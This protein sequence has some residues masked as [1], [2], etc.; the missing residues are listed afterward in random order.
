MLDL[1]TQLKYFTHLYFYVTIDFHVFPYFLP[2]TLILLPLWGKLTSSFF[3]NLLNELPTCLYKFLLFSTCLINKLCVILRNWSH[4]YFL[5]YSL[6][7]SCMYMHTNTHIKMQQALKLRNI[8]RVGESRKGKK[9][10]SFPNDC[11]HPIIASPLQ[12]PQAC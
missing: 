4:Y 5:L 9:E 11:T 3:S 10:F 12:P 8:Q 6:H 1:P 2:T 7:C